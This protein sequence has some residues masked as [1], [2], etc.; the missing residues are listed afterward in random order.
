MNDDM[1]MEK[2]LITLHNR[3]TIDKTHTTNV[4]TVHGGQ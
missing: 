2:G 3:P 4:P 1:Y